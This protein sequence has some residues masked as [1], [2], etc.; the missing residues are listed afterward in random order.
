[1]SSC[2]RGRG[3]RTRSDELL[4]PVL[5]RGEIPGPDYPIARARWRPRKRVL[6]DKR[7]IVAVEVIEPLVPGNLAEL[8]RARES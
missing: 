5:R 7:Q 3:G 4:S 6:E 1:M 8:V 2:S